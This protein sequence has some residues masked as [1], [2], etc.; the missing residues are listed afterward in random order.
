MS[1]AVGWLQRLW[2]KVDT[3]RLD[4]NQHCAPLDGVRGIAVLLVLMYDCLK[5]DPLGNPVTFAARKVASAGWSGVDLFFVLSGFLITGVLLETRGH[6]GYW[7][8]FLLRRVVRIFPLYYA[9]LITVF[10]V[11]PLGLWMWGSTG[12]IAADFEA[13]RQNQI[14]YWFYAQNWF[15]AWQ[16]AW[17][18]GVPIKHFWS[19]AI[20]EQF[21][22]VWPFAVA[23]FARRSLGWLCLGLSLFSLGLR[24]VLISQG[25]SP[26]T[27]FVMTVTR[28]DGLCIG[29]LLAVALR[30]AGVRERL[31]AWLPSLA[32]FSFCAVVVIDAVFPILKSESYPATSFGHT[33]LA[34]AF[35]MLI[36]AAQ[37]VPKQH[38]V[39]QVLSFRVLTLLGKYSYAIYV[40]HRFVYWGVMEFDWSL[41]PDSLRGWSIFGV[42]LIG[43]ILA[44][45]VSWVLLEQ[46]CLSLKKFFPRPDAKT[47]DLDHG[48]SEFH[49]DNCHTKST[50]TSPESC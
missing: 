11:I 7:K 27:V 9:T 24:L 8:S 25:V 21:Y 6:A 40:F 14:W 32:V 12:T 1:R 4:F 46:P 23:Y 38:L 44:A 49:P 2:P 26:V 22:L 36:G 48:I 50:S 34:F 45:R 16:Q 3:E 15:Y 39:A 42:T 28:L 37:V 47:G 20:E 31:A 17:P 18:S 33:I 29:A 5:L 19:L 43:T 30:S 10:C 13:A 35:A 41:L